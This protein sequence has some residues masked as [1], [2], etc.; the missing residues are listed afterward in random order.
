MRS[1]TGSKYRAAGRRPPPP[2]VRRDDRSTVPAR[3]HGTVAV[4]SRTGI[5]CARA[6]REATMRPVHDRRV[7]LVALAVAALV[8]PTA[9]AKAG[10]G[11]GEA[12]VLELANAPEDR[13]ASGRTWT[14]ELRVQPPDLF[15]RTSP[16]PTVL[17]LDELTGERR[18]FAVGRSGSRFIARVVFPEEG[19]WA[20][21]VAVGG[22]FVSDREFVD[23]RRG[24]SRRDAV[25]VLV[26]SALL[27]VGAL[28]LGVSALRH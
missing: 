1:Y 5:A 3:A 21:G 20:Y 8:A 10:Q 16:R 17:I 15:R 11:P 13:I 27:V 26:A 24:R 6:V 28:A 7:R 9:A 18:S 14:A 23:V 22:R 4:V 25:P 19:R 2:C 12:E